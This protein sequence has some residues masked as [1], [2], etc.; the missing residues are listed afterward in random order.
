MNKKL[1][2]AHFVCGLLFFSSHLLAQSPGGIPQPSVW[3]QGNLSANAQSKA[4]LNFNPALIMNNNKT[5]IEIPDSIASLRRTTIFTVYQSKQAAQ[6]LPVWAMTGPFGDLT[7]SSSQVFSKSF[8]TG[9]VFAKKVQSRL[10]AERP[11]ALVHTYIN[12]SADF[13]VSGNIDYP[14]PLIDFGKTTSSRADNHAQGLLAE[15]IL[16]E[17]ILTEQDIAKVESYLALKYGITLERNY[18]NGSGEIVWNTGK[19]SIYSNNIAGIAR[20]DQSAL[21]QKQSTSSNQPGQLLMGIDTVALSNSENPGQLNDKDYLVWGDNGQANTLQPPSTSFPGVMLPERKWLM[22]SSGTTSNKIVTELKIDTK[23]VMPENF[24]KEKFCLVIDRSGLGDFAAVNCEIIMPDNIS[25]DGMASFRK[26]RW[27]PDGSGK[28]VFSFG[29]KTGPVNPSEQH[30]LFQLYPNPVND[31]HY[32]L[33]VALKK[34]GD[35]QIRIDDL[36][37]HPVEIKRGSGKSF[38]TFSGNISR[39][40]GVYTVRLITAEFELSRILIVQ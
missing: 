11:T 22:K 5:S 19:D 6:E 32:H 23:T 30:T 26:L 35:V 7:L 28:D 34:P 13:A 18:L 4:M 31:G 20:D 38:Y 24:P 37:Q 9:I 3:L 27:D 14:T 2:R 25:A 17:K 16:Y 40:K 10:P 8:G 29:L 39:A 15:F 1:I 21:F 12:R 33:V 36:Y